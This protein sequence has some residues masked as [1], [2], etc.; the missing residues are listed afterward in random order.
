MRHEPSGSQ[1]LTPGPTPAANICRLALLP[2]PQALDEWRAHLNATYASTLNCTLPASADAAAAWQ[3][4]VDFNCEGEVACAQLAMAARL[5]VGGVAEVHGGQLRLTRAG[6]PTLSSTATGVENELQ[7]VVP[8]AFDQGRP[9]T[10]YGGGAATIELS[11]GTHMLYLRVDFQLVVGGRGIGDDDPYVIVGHSGGGISVSYGGALPLEQ[12]GSL[13]GGSGLRV[14]FL[15]RGTAVLWPT[16]RV[17]Y[18]GMLLGSARCDELRS[19]RLT[20]VSITAS[21]SGV[22]VSY[23]GQ[24]LLEQLPWPSW[25]WVP[26][27]H[28]LL[29]FSASTE[30]VPT[31]H[32]IDDVHVATGTHVDD[33]PVP[34]SISLNGQ[35]FVELDQAL[36]YTFGRSTA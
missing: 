27:P 28:W 17:Y 15:T 22:S 5:R 36:V 6:Y 26:Q 34:V 13:G 7:A 33:T 24:P 29:A 8:A 20:P 18:D 25:G 4:R 19:G 11:P 31:N 9:E 3:L 1:A 32:W 21:S 30:G 16:V 10:T 23:A 12:M 14:Q 35:Q 2:A